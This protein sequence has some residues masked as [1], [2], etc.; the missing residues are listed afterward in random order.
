MKGKLAEMLDGVD[1]RVEIGTKPSEEVTFVLVVSE[2][3]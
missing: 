3:C 1:D 2:K